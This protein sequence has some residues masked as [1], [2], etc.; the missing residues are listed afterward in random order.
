V[1]LAGARE[2]DGGKRA[3]CD[4]SLAIVLASCD[5]GDGDDGA[6]GEDAGDEGGEGGGGGEDGAA[7]GRSVI[8]SDC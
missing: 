4:G 2:T 6:D 5:E 8:S 1:T 7:W 3:L